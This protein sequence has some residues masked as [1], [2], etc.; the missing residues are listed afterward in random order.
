MEKSE[1]YTR[2]IPIYVIKDNKRMDKK[3]LYNIHNRVFNI[4]SLCL[5]RL[6]KSWDMTVALFKGLSMTVSL[7]L[8]T[9]KI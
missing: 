5:I 4:I 6:Y 3:K 9:Q 8:N 2:Q 7:L 1:I